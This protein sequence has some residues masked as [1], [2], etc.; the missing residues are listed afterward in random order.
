MINFIVTLRFFST[1]LEEL[2]FFFKN[3]HN[4]TKMITTANNTSPITTDA[5]YDALNDFVTH[6]LKYMSNSILFMHSHERASA[7]EFSGH[8]PYY[9]APTK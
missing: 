9:S 3:S 4:R 7:V 1:S 5:I 2:F 8:V 6:V